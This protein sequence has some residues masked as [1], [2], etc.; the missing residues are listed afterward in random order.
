MIHY[1]NAGKRIFERSNI[2]ETAGV[3][4][5]VAILQVVLITNGCAF[6][7]LV[8]EALQTGSDACNG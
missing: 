1:S 8:E 5:F 6:R 7:F 2:Y 3:A 4:R